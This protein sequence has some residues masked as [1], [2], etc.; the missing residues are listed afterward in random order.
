[1]RPSSETDLSE[2]LAAQAG[3]VAL[4]GG[5]T[6][7]IG[8]P[9]DGVVLETDGLAGVR[10]YEPG[11]LTLVAGAGTPLAE[12]EALLA[13][14]G[15]RLA[16][17]PPDL[18][19]LLGRTGASTLGGVVAANA[20]GPRRVAAGAARDFCLGVRLVDGAGRI[21]SNGGRVMKNVTGYDLVKLMAGSHGTLGVLT[22]VSLKVLPVPETEATLRLELDDATRAMQAMS[23]ALGTPWEVT[24]AAWDGAAALLRI[25]GFEQSVHYRAER[26]RAHL[27]PFAEAEIITHRSAG[28]WQAV[29]DVSALEGAPVVLRISI[30]PSALPELLAQVEA[31]HRLLTDWGGGL[32]WLGL[33]AEP[34]AAALAQL[35]AWCTV[36]GGHCTLITG[37]EALRRAQP[38]FQQQPT[39]LATLSRGLRARF[40]PK[41]I[42]NTGMMH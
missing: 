8:R 42:L 13:G 2:M 4:R 7:T 3:T 5:G 32:V 16:F 20:S 36:K 35:Q 19:G 27:A 41:G 25:E 30:Q 31:D 24:G 1:M 37:P 34:G 9:V 28:L 39:A 29:R 12:I 21:I 10:L 40:D 33:E 22:E 14:E 26:L 38:S 17:E 11:A 18:S 15:Q 6:R 23:A